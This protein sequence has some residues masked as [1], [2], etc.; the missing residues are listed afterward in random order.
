MFGAHERS[1]AWSSGTGPWSQQVLR[2]PKIKSLG[3]EGG[4]F[5]SQIPGPGIFGDDAQ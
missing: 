3:G 2:P 4:L 5:T 1:Q